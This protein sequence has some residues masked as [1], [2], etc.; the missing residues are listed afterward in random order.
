M[1]INYDRDLKFDLKKIIKKVNNKTSFV[2]LGGAVAFGDYKKIDE[3][4]IFCKIL[5]KK[6]IPFLLDEAYV[7]FAPSSLVKLTKKYKNLFVL[8]TLSKSWGAAGIRFGYIIGDKSVVNLLNNLQLTYPISNI[9]LKFASYLLNN[10]KIN[11]KYS[12]Q[13]K[14]IRIYRNK[15]IKKK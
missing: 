14:K 10:K 15:N 7:D 13:T 2:I 9:S 6:K 5:K 12:D 11:K 4:E 8:K 1:S 3:I